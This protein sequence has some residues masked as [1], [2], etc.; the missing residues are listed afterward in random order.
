MDIT[1]P[2]IW[3]LEFFGLNF[4]RLAWDTRTYGSP[5]RATPDARDVEPILTEI[6]RMRAPVQRYF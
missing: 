1:S 5:K 4:A 3:F 6:V 2:E